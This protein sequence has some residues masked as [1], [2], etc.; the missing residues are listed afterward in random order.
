MGV[1]Q[2]DPAEGANVGRRA[3]SAAIVGA[4]LAGVLLALAWRGID[5]YVPCGESF[6]CQGLPIGDHGCLGIR[7]GTMI[8][9]CDFAG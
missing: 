8:E 3:K 7:R 1:S 9:C 2:R 5:V 4:L 6:T